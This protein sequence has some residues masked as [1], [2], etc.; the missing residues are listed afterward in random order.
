MRDEDNQTPLH[1]S[2][3]YGHKEVVHYLVEV[4]KCDVGESF[5]GVAFTK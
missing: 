5:Y 3:F 4:V 1:I 2:C